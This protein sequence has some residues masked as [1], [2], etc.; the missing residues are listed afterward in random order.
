MFSRSLVKR[1]LAWDQLYRLKKNLL[2]TKAFGVDEIVF[3]MMAK[4]LG[5]KPKSYPKETGS[6][7]R[8]RPHYTYEEPIKLMNESP[9][10][11]LLHPVYRIMKDEAR[12][13]IRY[14]IGRACRENFFNS[15]EWDEASI[16]IRTGFG[17]MEFVARLGNRLIHVWQDKDGTP[18]WRK[19]EE[20]A[21]GVRGAPIFMENRNGNFEVIAP[22]KSGG[23]GYWWRNNSHPRLPWHSPVVIG[24]GEVDAVSLMNTNSGKLAA[25]A[26]K[27]A[28]SSRT[29]RS[30]TD[31]GIRFDSANE[32]S[33][34]ELK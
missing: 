7:V 27:K 17:N 4:R 13:L 9:S 10:S 16:M 3:V 24:K 23:I 12:T 1:L 6:A 21:R 5:F 2:R 26:E 14:L 33:K 34:E 15:G 29:S 28:V 18:N 32:W 31:P 8:Y 22:L 11:F 20:F 30:A 19:S 25:V